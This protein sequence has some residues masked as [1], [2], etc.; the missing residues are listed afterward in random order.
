MEQKSK[1]KVTV[2][3]GPF[4]Q[5]VDPVLCLVPTGK[6]KLASGVA[7]ALEK[8]FGQVERVGNFSKGTVC[9]FDE[10]QK[11]IP[12]MDSNIVVFMPHL[13][14][15]LVGVSPEKIRIEEGSVG[16]IEYCRA[17]KI[18]ENIKQIH[19]EVLLVP[20]KIIDKDKLLG[21][22]VRWMLKL[23]AALAVYSYLGESKTFHIVDALGNDIKLSKE[24]LPEVL[25]R[26][27]YRMSHAV[28]RRSVWK[29]PEIPDVPYL[30]AYVDFSRRM[31]PAFTDT[32]RNIAVGR[33]PG[34][35]SFRCA[36]GFL[37]ARAG[38]GFVV[39][40]RN[41]AKTGLTEKDF[42]FV[43]LDLENGKLQFWG[44][45][46]AKPSIDSPVHRLIYKELPWVMGIVHGHLHAKGNCVYE[47]MLTR[48]PCGAE[49]EAEEILKVAPGTYRKLWIVNV[50]G[51]GFVAL[52]GDEDPSEAL[53]E[54]SRMGFDRKL[55]CELS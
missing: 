15:I 42:V 13:P 8:Y 22:V 43:S 10:L 41:V 30:R 1:L 9:T 52:I 27:I 55:E 3:G 38:D 17:V 37:S 18:V 40:M 49:N 12:G 53:D 26:E 36:K 21:D 54:L 11:M 33:W 45:K 51:H 46:D 4:A 7:D 39:T 23:H 44:R 14:N 2:V 16:R 19:P 24:K 32:I 35:F 31:E 6:G 20:F 48:W 29:G 50:S 28:R 47:N 34:N 5:R 25:A